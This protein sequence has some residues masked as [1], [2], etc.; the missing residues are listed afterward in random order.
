MYPFAIASVTELFESLQNSVALVT[1]VFKVVPEGKMHQRNITYGLLIMGPV[2]LSLAPGKFTINIQAEFVSRGEEFWDNNGW[3]LIFCLCVPLVLSMLLFD[4]LG[5]VRS[6]LRLSTIP[7]IRSLISCMLLVNL[8]KQRQFLLC[9]CACVRVCVLTFVHISSGWLRVH[10][11]VCLCVCLSN[12]TCVHYEWSHVNLQCGMPVSER[13]HACTY[14]HTST[15]RVRSAVLQQ[16]Y[17]G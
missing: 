14:E 13:I 11:P 9:S 4:S 10:V 5:V 1:L 7:F 12:H 3:T 8:E 6:V 17:G 2:F 15:H 16:R